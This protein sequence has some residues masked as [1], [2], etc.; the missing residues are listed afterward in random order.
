MIEDHLLAPRDV[1][2]ETR[3]LVAPRIVDKSIAFQVR[4]SRARYLRYRFPA[5]I[6]GS[7]GTRPTLLLGLLSEHWP[8]DESRRYLWAVYEAPIPRGRPPSPPCEPGAPSL[9]LAV[10]KSSSTSE[11][12]FEGYPHHG[13]PRERASAEG[14]GLRRAGATGRGR[15]RCRAEGMAL[16][17]WGHLG[18]K[19]GRG[20][21]SAVVVVVVEG[22]M[23]VR[24]EGDTGYTDLP[25]CLKTRTKS[26]LRLYEKEVKLD[27]TD[28][29]SNGTAMQM[30]MLLYNK[31]PETGL[32]G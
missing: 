14:C 21:F 24:G 28:I 11:W 2:E 3:H 7:S 10:H 32:Y 13:G 27:G 30:E 19:R 31:R 20:G 15:G 25:D 8:I 26:S 1:Y 22:W 9:R 4:R 6:P 29:R 5:E 16:W 18:E 17:W 12:G 23:D